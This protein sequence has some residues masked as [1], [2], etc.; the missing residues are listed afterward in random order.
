MLNTH[1][2][3]EV[4]A[5]AFNGAGKTDILIRSE[6]RNVFI[7]ECKVWEGAESLIRT[8]AQLF[9][10]ATWRDVRLC[11]VLFVERRDFTVAVRRA[12]EALGAHERFRAWL[13]AEEQETEFRAQMAWPG[14]DERLVTLHVSTFLTP[15]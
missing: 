12:R 8:V 6:D 7:C 5:E 11:I 3:G 2:A 15:R 13:V 1:Y 4:H 10:Y 14:D 9:S